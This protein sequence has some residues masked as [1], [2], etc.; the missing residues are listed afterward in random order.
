MGAAGRLP[1]MRPRFDA[2]DRVSV[3]ELGKPGHVRTPFYVRRREGVVLHRCGS[4]LNPEE[5]SVG[6]VCG[7]VVPLYRVGFAMTDLWDDYRG[8]PADMLCLE[9]Y[10]HW[11]APAAA[12][13]LDGEPARDNEAFEHGGRP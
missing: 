4:Y 1:V 6:K 7:P 2:G 13:P 5:L 9:L 10:D 11:L 3:L 12:A 8:S